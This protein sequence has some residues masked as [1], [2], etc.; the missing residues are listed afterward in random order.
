MGGRV[1]GKVAIVTGGAM[2]LGAAQATL[3]SEEGATVV[4]TDIAEAEG[5]AVAASLPRPGL[6]IPHDVSSE[7]GWAR[8][9]AEV[10]DRYGRLDVLVNNAAIL[11]SGSIEE[12][13]FAN[14]KKLQEVNA[15][16]VFLGCQAAVRMMRKGGGGSIV[17]IASVAS[18][19]GEPYA[20]GYC[21][22]KGAVRS[23]T[24]SVAIHCMEAGHRIRCNSVHPG[25]MATPM[26]K[27]LREA[28][29]LP[30]AD[31]SWGDPRQLA[32]SVLYLASDESLLVT[33]AE[34]LVDNG[35]TAAPPPPGAWPPP[36]T[37]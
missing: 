6:F 29:G 30:D 26:V 34:L 11:I 25:S 22:A 32:Y 1:E 2:G 9:E 18:H 23:L 14:W 21:A 10:M 31:P 17:N 33:G 4:V 3:L 16:S 28:R 12:L 36:Q 27:R 24:K 5:A 35:R 8:V 19:V 37:I 15:D 13:S 20:A 7:A